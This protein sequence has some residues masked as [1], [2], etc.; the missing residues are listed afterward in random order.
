MMSKLFFFGIFFVFLSIFLFEY[1]IVGQAVYGDGR[2]Y[3]AFTRSLYFS[4]DIDISDE[5]A[6]FYSP[7]SNN[8]EL[9]FGTVAQELSKT[10][11]ITNSFSRTRSAP[12]YSLR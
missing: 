11:L 7:E 10:K 8:T 6:H 12:P 1:A 5:M 2:Y 3:W 4:N 9:F